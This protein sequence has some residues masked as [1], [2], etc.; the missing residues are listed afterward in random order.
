MIIAHLIMFFLLEFIFIS[1]PLKKNLFS[2]FNPSSSSSVYFFFSATNMNIFGDFLP[3]SI[4][5]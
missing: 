3:A 5:H 4:A 1:F 2:S